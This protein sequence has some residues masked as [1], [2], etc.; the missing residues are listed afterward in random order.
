MSLRNITSRLRRLRWLGL[1]HVCKAIRCRTRSCHSLRFGRTAHI[2]DVLLQAAHALLTNV[3]LND[4]SLPVV[5]E[6]GSGLKRLGHRSL[7]LVARPR[8]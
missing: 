3:L 8:R 4:Y 7:H 5:L 6:G 2:G 1:R